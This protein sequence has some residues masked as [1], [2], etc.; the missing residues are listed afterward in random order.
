MKHMKLIVIAAFAT[1]AYGQAPSVSLQLLSETP[2][3]AQAT[4]QT[5]VRDASGKPYFYLAAKAGGLQ[6][7][8]IQNIAQPMLKKVVSVSQLSGLEVMNATQRGDYLYLA[9]GN[10]FGNNGQKPGLA[11]LDVSDPLSPVIKSKWIWNVQDKGSASV[12]LSG[13]YAYL[14][15][16]TQGLILLDIAEPD[17]IK[18]VSQIIPDPDFPVPNPSAA[19]VPNARGVAVRDDIAY[20][21]YDAGG[22]RVINV[23]DKVNPVETGRYANS[24]LGDKP[25]AFNNVVLDGNTAFVAADYCGMEVLNIS[26]TSNITQV[27]WWNPWQCQSPTNIWVGSPGHTNQISLE[28]ANHLIFMSSA[29]SELSILDVSD[30]AQPKLAGGYGAT[31]DQL[32]TWGMTLDGNHVFLTYITAAIPFVSTWA[33]VKILEWEKTTG[34]EDL[35]LDFPF[36]AYPNPFSSRLNL[37]FSLDRRVALQIRLFDLEGNMVEEM[38]NDTFEA[39]IHTL[40]TKKDLPAGIYMAHIRNAAGVIYQKIVKY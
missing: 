19:H 40:S 28:P 24:V 29:Q 13:N 11:I 10:F 5:V 31:N 8:D 6:V 22:L 17:S 1:G 35:P 36:K 14:C 3:A 16:M 9:L 20:L 2:A 27:S 7:Y 32:G 33:G 25:I 39:G 4:P 23:T 30:I 21:C 18:F 12:T 34:V 37:E 26:D 15:A 38:A